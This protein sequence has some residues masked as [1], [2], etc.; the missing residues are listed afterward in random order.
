MTTRNKRQGQG[1]AKLPPVSTREHVER[2]RKA[3]AELERLA[4]RPLTTT[5]ERDAVLAELRDIRFS[6]R[7]VLASPGT[8]LPDAMRKLA[9]D[10]LFRTTRAIE[11]VHA[12]CAKTPQ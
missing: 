3:V 1:H 10:I 11:E 4:G 9:R 8:V 5:A 12:V 2:I 7:R 6:A